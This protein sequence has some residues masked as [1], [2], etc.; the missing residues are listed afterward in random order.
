[1]VKLRP[2]PEPPAV[3]RASC[4][5]Q[6]FV[7]ATSGAFDLLQT[8][9]PPPEPLTSSSFNSNLSELFL[10]GPVV[11]KMTQLMPLHQK[12]YH[13]PIL[14]GLWELGYVKLALTPVCGKKI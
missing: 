6:N 13:N 9:R 7:L 12:D 3:Y 10:M 1:V 2:P 14:V 11:R 8:L 5:L 4:R